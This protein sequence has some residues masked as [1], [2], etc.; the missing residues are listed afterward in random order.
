ME[1]VPDPV[2]PEGGDEAPAAPAPS[3]GDEV[4]PGPDLAGG[5]VVVGVD[6]SA[7]AFAALQWALAE[8]ALRHA[9]VE[10]VHTWT[11]PMSA[12]PFGGTLSVPLDEVAVDAT[13]RQHVEEMVGVALG[14]SPDPTVPVQVTILPGTPA[15]ALVEVAADADLLV[16]GS[17]GR[18]GLSRLVL[19]SVAMAVV[20]HSPCP[21]VVVRVPAPD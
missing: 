10:V 6:D 15:L 16:V 2:D 17:H 3:G 12:L 5:R 13:A 21:V 9:S 14:A 7:Q 20:Q 18:T 19:G 4:E 8:A 1:A 11:P